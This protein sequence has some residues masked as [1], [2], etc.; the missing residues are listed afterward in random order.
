MEQ[1]KLIKTIYTSSNIQI[2][3]HTRC[4]AHL[5]N[6]PNNISSIGSPLS[7][8]CNFHK[9]IKLQISIENDELISTHFIKLKIV[10][11]PFIINFRGTQVG[12]KVN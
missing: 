4:S 9:K 1:Q 8:F 10:C 3:A 5:E 7:Y 2:R 6:Y 11:Y 12:E